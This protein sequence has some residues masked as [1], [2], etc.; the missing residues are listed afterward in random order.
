MKQ[1]KL[2]EFS[3]AIYYLCNITER[4]NDICKRLQKETDPNIKEELE[5]ELTLPF[6]DVVAFG[7]G[8]P[9]V[10]VINKLCVPTNM[11]MERKIFPCYCNQ[12]TDPEKRIKDRLYP[13]LHEDSESSFNCAK[14]R[15][16]NPEYCLIYKV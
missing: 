15:L 16:H 11:N 4:Q 10:S 3:N 5:K 1:L 8:N 2:V 14:E 7:K 6:K 9:P 13:V 12:E